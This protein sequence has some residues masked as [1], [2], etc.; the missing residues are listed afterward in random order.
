MVVSS[1]K[2]D[3][4]APDQTGSAEVSGSG[5]LIMSINDAVSWHPSHKTM[6]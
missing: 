6:D 2:H 4:V 5:G 3:Q 1:A